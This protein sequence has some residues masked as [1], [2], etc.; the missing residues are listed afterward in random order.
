MSLCQN[1]HAVVRSFYSPS[2]S[3]ERQMV[4]LEQSL[5]DEVLSGRDSFIQEGLA[6]WYCFSGSVECEL[7]SMIKAEISQEML[8]Y[9]QALISFNGSP[10]KLKGWI[11]SELAFSFPV[12]VANI[13]NDD[14]DTITRHGLQYV[15]SGSHTLPKLR[16]D[17]SSLRGG[18]E[19]LRPSENKN[20]KSSTIPVS[21]LLMTITTIGYLRDEDKKRVDPARTWIQDCHMIHPSCNSSARSYFPTRLID[22]KQGKLV[23]TQQQPG[24]FQ[25]AAL[26]HCWGPNMPESGMTKTRTLSSHM[27]SIEL[28][29][30]PKSFRD[31]LVITRSLDIPYIWIDSLCIIQD[32]RED[33]ENESAQMGLVYSHAWCT[34]AASSA[35]SCHH[36]IHLFREDRL[37]SCDVIL[38]GD[39]GSRVRV[40]ISQPPPTWETFFNNNPLN[41]RGW[42]FQERELSPR[43][44]HFSA[45]QMWWECR[46]IRDQE[47]PALEDDNINEP[48]TSIRRKTELMRLQEQ[49][50]R[51][52]ADYARF[53]KVRINK[54]HDATIFTGLIVNQVVQLR[55]LDNMLMASTPLTSPAM[56]Q[57][58]I[59]TEARYNT[60]LKVVQDYSARIFTVITDRFPAL[61]GLASEMQ[62]THGG[63]YVAGV[64][65]DDMLR[66]LLW[67]R[68]LKSM[69]STSMHTPHRR[70]SEYRAPS[71][72]WAAIDQAI[73]Y[74]LVT[75]NRLQIDRLR[76]TTAHI[77]NVSLVPAGSDPKGRLKGGSMLIRGK[78]KLY[79]PSSVSRS[80]VFHFDFRDEVEDIPVYLLSLFESWFK[81]SLTLALALVMIEDPVPVFRR[82]GV[83]S[84]VLSEWFIDAMDVKIPII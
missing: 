29:E 72:S 28:P 44:L 50:A 25:Y 22:V 58:L 49:L 6:R 47:D 20:G 32:S 33:W 41:T 36:G 10:S 17:D 39:Q 71:W 30:L 69:H 13:E 54:D 45:D 11:K 84:D 57:E 63:E 79:T 14:H 34:I 65:R 51:A 56:L 76:P 46:S 74:D 68:D 59:I 64:W 16:N 26:T 9:G 80:M 66:S 3:D 18:E 15:S 19:R 31:A 1:C 37:Y 21:W 52:E 43:I 35:K 8:E 4:A 23:D 62:A 61:S 75:I 70:P 38:D 73:S 81:D 60:W 24:P 12:H 48:A 77:E 27:K 5:S 2:E 53:A 83:V 55:C 78:L 42:T 40:S 67:R 82:I 7:C